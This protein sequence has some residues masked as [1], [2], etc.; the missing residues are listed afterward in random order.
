MAREKIVF[1]GALGEKLCGRLDIPDD[2]EP[3]TYVLFAHCFTGSK[4]VL[5]AKRIARS[6]WLRG[7]A[8][9]RFDFTFLGDSE[10][11][12]TNTTFSS[13]VEDLV[14][15]AKYLRDVKRAPIF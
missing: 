12:F 7:F 13:N 14:A 9:F 10:G 15:A 5:A 1:E 4:E 6:L 2:R 11:N 3:R 8:V